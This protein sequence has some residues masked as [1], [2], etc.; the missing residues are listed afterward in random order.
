MILQPRVGNSGVSGPPSPM[1]ATTV[2]DP[3][4][5]LEQTVCDDG[6]V[7]FTRCT[8]KHR[9]TNKELAS[10][11]DADILS[12]SAANAAAAISGAF[13]VNGSPTQTAMADRAGARTQFAQ[14]QGI[15]PR[16]QRKILRRGRPD[17]SAAQALITPPPTSH[18]N[19]HSGVKRRFW[20]RWQR[21]SAAL[22][23][24]FGKIGRRQTS[25]GGS[26]YG[27][28]AEYR[29]GA[30]E[31]QEKEQAEPRVGSTSGHVDPAPPLHKACVPANPRMKQR[32]AVAP[33]LSAVLMRPTASICFRWGRPPLPRSVF[34]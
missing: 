22:R 1:G 2:S 11:E 7:D 19:P 23:R 8:A 32:F 12:L 29:S 6:S 14:F 26:S 21:L 4:V 31:E 25:G 10:D 28:R 3:L 27:I 9:Q 17:P 15:S 18:L 34:A 5:F 16:G 33:H 20:A 13:V 30:R 24:P